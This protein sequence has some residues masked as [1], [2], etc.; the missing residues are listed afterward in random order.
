MQN[1]WIPLSCHISSC[2]AVNVT[3]AFGFFS[4]TYILILRRTLTDALN[5]ERT[6]GPRPAPTTI[7][8]ACNLKLDFY[9]LF[10][11]RAAKSCA[12][13]FCVSFFVRNFVHQCL[14]NG[15]LVIDILDGILFEYFIRV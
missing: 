15:S 9:M 14:L 7:T 13:R 4:T 6:S 8:I 11:S 1:K 2:R 12:Y 10:S 5:A 3:I